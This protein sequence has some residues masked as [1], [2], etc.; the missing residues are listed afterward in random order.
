MLG[1]AHDLAHHGGGLVRPTLGDRLHERAVQSDV[2]AVRT[3]AAALAERLAH[4]VVQASVQRVAG[5]FQHEGVQPDVRDREVDATVVGRGGRE[6]VR[7]GEQC[8]P[9]GRALLA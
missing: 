6:L 2:V 8:L 9:S 3:D 5:Q 1:A 7:G 4:D